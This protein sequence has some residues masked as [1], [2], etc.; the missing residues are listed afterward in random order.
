MAGS[1]IKSLGSAF[2]SKR[3]NIA[4]LCSLIFMVFGFSPFIYPLR[5]SQE[6]ACKLAVM[7]VVVC[8]CIRNKWLLAYL[9][10]SILLVFIFPFPQSIIVLQTLF[11]YVLFMQLLAD[12]LNKDRI[13]HLLDCLC[14]ICVIQAGMMFLQYSGIWFIVFDSTTENSASMLMYKFF[15]PPFS[16]EIY[17]HEYAKLTRWNLT[18]F[19]SNPNMASGFIAMCLPAFLR[20]RMWVFLPVVLTALLLVNSLLGTLTAI[21]IL[22]VY[23]SRYIKKHK[24][25][26]IGLIILAVWAWLFWSGEWKSFYRYDRL[27]IWKFC[28]EKIIPKHPV[29]GYGLGNS[30]RLWKWIQKDCVVNEAFTHPHNEFINVAIEQGLIGLGLIMGF[31][32]SSL[33]I[34]RKVVYK[35]KV[36]VLLG[37]MAGLL[38]C[39]ASF[40]VHVTIG[41]ILAVYLSI[42]QYLNQTEGAV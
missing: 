36:L 13:K 26:T 25:L 10:Y 28:A 30:W 4:I 19:T 1:R 22:S 14:L 16:V 3:F 41:V 21:I 37:V 12:K 27:P 6:V 32:T 5:T 7:A 9:V 38:N 2:V 11:F 42:M 31:I 29:M 40:T 33:Y 17:N 18:G 34:F 24:V 8:L 20:K 35:H 23:L 39:M 15:K